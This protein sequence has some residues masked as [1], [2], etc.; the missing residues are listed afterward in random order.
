MPFGP[1]TWGSL[2][3]VAIAGLLLGWESSRAT[4]L[5]VLMGLAVM[6]GIVCV[7]LGGRI[8]GAWSGKDPGACVID[9][10]CGQAIALIPAWWAGAFREQLILIGVA[11]AG[12]RLLDIAKPWPI[13]RLQRLAGGWGILLDDV[14][15]GVG[16][17]VPVGVAM[18][19]LGR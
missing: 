16:A 9:E 14:A 3:P 8:E 10:V 2:L 6:S 12:F 4:Y 19:L 13:G 1:G 7:M 17:L 5:G 15:A 18:V 11:F